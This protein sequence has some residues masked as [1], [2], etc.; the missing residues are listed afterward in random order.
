[1]SQETSVL[2]GALRRIS[3][4]GSLSLKAFILTEASE[5]LLCLLMQAWSSRTQEVE[6]GESGV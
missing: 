5:L 3:S 6:A 4:V 1:M 2:Q